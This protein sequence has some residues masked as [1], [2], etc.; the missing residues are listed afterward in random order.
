MT[1]RVFVFVFSSLITSIGA[2]QQQEAT[3]L[4]FEEYLGYVKYYHPYVKQANLLLEEGQAKLMKA[5]GAFDPKLEVDYDKKEFKNSTYFNKLNSSFKI[6]TWFG[7]E[8]KGG[9]A[10]N[11]GEYLNPELTVPD[12]GLYNVGVSIPLARDLLTNKRMATLRKSKIYNQQVVA[13]RQLLVNSIISEASMA[14]F[15]WL[16]AYREQQIYTTFL[17][18][19][20]ERL[21]G[22]KKN[23]ELG[24]NPAIDTLEAGII[25]KNRKLALE[26]A[27]IMFVKSTLEVSNFL[28]LDNN[29]P[30][31][32][33]PEVH[34]DL[35]TFNNVDQVLYT[36]QLDI[37][38]TNLDNHPKIKI[39]E[40]KYQIQQ[41]EKRLKRNNLLPQID[42]E[43][44]FLTED[45]Q[46][47]NTLNT[48][49]YK[50]G[51]KVNFPLF[52]RKERGDLKLADLK[53]NNIAYDKMSTSLNLKNKLDAVNNEISSFN[54]QQ[55]LTTNIVSD[56]TRLLTA[57][58]RKFE[59]GESSLFLINSRESKLIEAK[60]KAVKIENESLNTKASLFELINTVE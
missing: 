2:A 30:V 21:N 13:E 3:M 18:N 44:N 49:N 42:L 20:A 40:N 24:E 57:E 36:S 48:V 59:L 50:T 9:L 58:E 8:I 10:E 14:Y 51:L 54:T 22:I 43:Y 45:I 4:T 55:D 5:R 6:P 46:V 12:N 27:R 19:A 23:F 52:L 15:K 26:R 38:S 11:S 53:L 39:L 7:I 32:L 41:I 33:Q 56:Y 17:D 29:I 28:W 34:P 35:N 47:L 37:E 31:E 16:K 1:L 60:L 25:Y